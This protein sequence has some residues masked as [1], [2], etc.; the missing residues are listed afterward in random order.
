VLD[1]LN[2]PSVRAPRS[3]DLVVVVPGIMG[4]RLVTDDGPIW[5][6]RRASGGWPWRRRRALAPLAV[7][8]DERD[9]SSSRVRPDG[10]FALPFWVPVLGGFEPYGDLVRRLRRHS[11]ADAAVVEFAYDWRLPVTVNASRLATWMDK[12]LGRWLGNPLQE[13]ARRADPAERPAQIVLAAHSM[14]GLL[15]RGLAEIPG[16]LDQVRAVVTMGTPF[17][18]S[19]RALELLAHGSGGPPTLSRRA[20]RDVGRTMPGLYDLLPTRACVF[21]GDALE[22]L[23]PSLV[24]DLGGDLDLAKASLSASVS[25]PSPTVLP[26]HRL[27]RGSRQLTPQSVRID[28]GS[29]TVQWH[30]YDLRRDGTLVADEIGRPVPV[31]R[32]GD[33]TVPTSA[34]RLHDVMPFDV[35]QQHG[36]LP[37]SQAVLDV[38]TGLLLDFEQGQELGEGGSRLALDAPISATPDETVPV[39][40]QVDEDPHLVRIVVE[41]VDTGERSTYHR[42]RAGDVPATLV[43]DLRFPGSGLYRLHASAGD[44]PVRHLIMVEPDDDDE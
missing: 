6:L 24:Q 18:G 31:D 34:A 38:F 22:S 11:V 5:G 17:G 13:A 14:G 7:G 28:A 9:G 4:S 10:L 29:L 35:A 40:V 8:E 19:I 26:G 30:T 15:V 12:E 3:H 20:L 41:N 42:A 44:E 2:D 1:V 33:G 32:R 16:T 43:F 39:A 23:E 25:R 27:I 37:T 36:A 21:T